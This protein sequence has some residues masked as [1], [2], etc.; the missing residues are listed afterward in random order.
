MTSRAV[1]ARNPLFLRDEE[2]ERL[3]E[4]LLLA[5]RELAV[6]S[7]TAR[8]ARGLSEAE[9]SI[10]YLVSRHGGATLADLAAVLGTPKQSLSRQVRGLAAAGLLAAGASRDDAR[11]RPLTLTAAGTEALQ[12]V[13]AVL[14]A[15]LRRAFLAAGPEAVDGL[16]RVLVELIDG[17]G[18]RWAGRRAA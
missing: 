7:D 15:R 4:L 17:P 14:K 2:V 1:P 8:A 12:A 13:A 9:A 5:G 18:R 10:L 16:E 6:R 11:R 3:L